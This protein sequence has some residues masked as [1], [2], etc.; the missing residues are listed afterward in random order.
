MMNVRRLLAIRNLESYT[1]IR[2]GRLNVIAVTRIEGLER[3]LQLSDKHHVC[4]ASDEKYEYLL[5]NLQYIEDQIE[6]ENFD[7]AIVNRYLD[8]SDDGEE[9]VAMFRRIKARRP[10]FLLILLLTDYDED[11]VFPLVNAG[12]YNLIINEN[13]SASGILNA[14]DKPAKDFDFSKYQV[15]EESGSKINISIPSFGAKEKWKSRQI[16]V[17]YSPS[18]YGVTKLAIDT[19]KAIVNKGASVCLLDLNVLK[20]TVFESLK[21]K[22]AERNNLVNIFERGKLDKLNTVNIDS[23]VVEY[24]GI[25]IIPGIYDLQ[26]IHYVHEE[27]YEGLF[28]KLHT[29]YDYIIVD[30]H[31]Y[32]D[33]TSTFVSL[34]YATKIIVP[35]LATKH[36]INLVNRYMKHFDA[37][38]DID[39]DKVIGVIN[40]F[41]GSSLSS[42]EVEGLSF[43]QVSHYIPEKSNKLFRRKTYTKA[44]E[45]LVMEL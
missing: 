43:L 16:I 9:I 6:R 31:G 34:K 40:R 29:I 4:V 27:D 24:K 17:F 19:A 33:L 11:V 32:Y 41:S 42:I 30:T 8:E 10:E 45:R 37:Y 39:K 28:E 25:S 38:K 13:I 1:R 22:E 44:I 35:Y 15:V 23:F 21:M 36:S 26:E 3:E 14:I 7:A 5:D 12:I 2:G 20:P 18:N